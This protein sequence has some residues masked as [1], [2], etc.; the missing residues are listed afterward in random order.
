MN[1]VDLKRYIESAIMD[2]M[3][4]KNIDKD[5]PFFKDVVRLVDHDYTHLQILVFTLYFH[6]IFFCFNNY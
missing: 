4:H 5:V 3:D 1:L 2:V 6:S